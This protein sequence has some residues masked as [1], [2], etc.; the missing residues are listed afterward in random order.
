MLRDQ[1]LELADEL[2]VSPEREIGVDPI[3]ERRQSKLPEPD[4]LGLRKRLPGEIT[5]RRSAPER[6][7][8]PQSVSPGNRV[9][10]RERAAFLLA[11]PCELEERFCPPSAIGVP[12]LLTERGPRTLNC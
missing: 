4:D 2:A 1:L 11:K 7:R 12:S 8:R 5:E 6:K 3:L 9:T 10:R